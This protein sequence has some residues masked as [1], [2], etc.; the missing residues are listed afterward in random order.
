MSFKKIN[1]PWFVSTRAH[2]AGHRVKSEKDPLGARAR[3]KSAAH[4]FFQRAVGDQ[5]QRQPPEKEGDRR[6]SERGAVGASWAERGSG[7][8]VLFF[9]AP[10]D[11]AGLGVCVG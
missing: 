2:G 6:W 3:G 10:P 5:E 8:T 4:L 7:A 1:P 11:L 9:G